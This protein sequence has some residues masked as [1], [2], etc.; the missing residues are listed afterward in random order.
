MRRHPSALV[1]QQILAV[2]QSHADGPQSPAE[3]VPQIVHPESLEAVAGL[4]PS[5]IASLP[6]FELLASLN[7]SAEPAAHAVPCDR[8]T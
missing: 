5:H 2:F 6:V 1:A 4:T 3:G 7:R 8:G